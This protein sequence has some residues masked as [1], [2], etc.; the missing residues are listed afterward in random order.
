M[1][2]AASW[3]GSRGTDRIQVRGA[4]RRVRGGLPSDLRPRASDRPILRRNTR[5]GDDSKERLTQNA[6]YKLSAGYGLRPVPH[7][8]Q[9][10]ALRHPVAPQPISDDA[11]RLVLQASEDGSPQKTGAKARLVARTGNAIT[12]R[13]PASERR[14]R[15]AGAA[16]RRDRRRRPR[17]R[18]SRR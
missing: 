13:G 16:A 4:I 14:W 6:P 10:L 17:S 12:R 11:P 5:S 8:G 1:R 18:G 3:S 7:L 9:N 2:M 15:R